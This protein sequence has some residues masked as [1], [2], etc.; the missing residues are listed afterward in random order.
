MAFSKDLTGDGLK[1][2]TL[3]VSGSSRPTRASRS[4]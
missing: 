2:D 3:I 1:G 4:R